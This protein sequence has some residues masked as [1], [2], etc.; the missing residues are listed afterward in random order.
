MIKK[1][2]VF[3]YTALVF[4]ICT[5]AC[6]LINFDRP[7]MII[8]R[9]SSN[10]INGTH[11]TFH[12]VGRSKKYVIRFDST[13]ESLLSEGISAKGSVV[14][15]HSF[16]GKEIRRIESKEAY[17]SMSG[18]FLVLKGCEDHKEYF[19]DLI[20]EE[21]RSYQKPSNTPFQFI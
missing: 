7:S 13:V 20:K 17:Y 5:S 4:S 15:I 1:Y 16:N 12:I 11:L 9:G 21:H 14:E 3:I 6:F 10:Y 19:I 18:G 8:S 2:K